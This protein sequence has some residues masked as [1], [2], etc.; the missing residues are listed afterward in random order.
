M[1]ELETD[2]LQ[3]CIDFIVKVFYSRNLI[4]LGSRVN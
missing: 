1:K 3:V 4:S 2:I